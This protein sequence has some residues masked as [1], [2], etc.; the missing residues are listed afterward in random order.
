MNPSN[1]LKQL[2]ALS[3]AAATIG[4]AANAAQA[5]PAAKTIRVLSAAGVDAA[6]PEA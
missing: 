2:A 5:A 4:L 6:S 1:L 3:M